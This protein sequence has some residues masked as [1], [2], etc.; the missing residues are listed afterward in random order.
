MKKLVLF[1]IIWIELMAIFV[2]F[3][4]M[5]F[6]WEEHGKTDQSGSSNLI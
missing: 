3:P 4:N 5:S 6:D 2:R 1:N